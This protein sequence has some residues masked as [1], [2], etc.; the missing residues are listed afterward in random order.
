MGKFNPLQKTIY[1]IVLECNKLIVRSIRP[2]VTIAQLQEITVN[3]LA[4]ECVKAK[5][6]KEESEISNYYFHNISHHI[7]LDT[8]DP[9]IRSLPLVPGNIISDEPGLYFKELGIGVRIEDDILVT[10]DGSFN[11]SGI[12][13]KEVEDIENA[14]AYCRD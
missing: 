4:K 5:L 13:I 7:G 2:G 14:M 11:L 3:F 12:I 8:H 9:S 1:N 10:E 6:I